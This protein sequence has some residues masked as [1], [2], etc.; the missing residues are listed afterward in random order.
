MAISMLA[1][2]PLDL[3]VGRK[4]TREELAQ[5][6]R[7]AIMAELDAVNL[8]L[9]IASSCED[10]GVRKLFQD[11]AKEEKAH[12]GEFLE[13]LLRLDP[14]QVRELEKGREEVREIMGGE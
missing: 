7:L 12:I 10:E 1:K 2:D 9:Q 3:A 4:L 14:E 11:V 13:A 8:Y 5:A 6:L